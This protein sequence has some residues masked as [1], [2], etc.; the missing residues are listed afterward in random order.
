MAERPIITV[1]YPDNPSQADHFEGP[2]DFIVPADWT[3]IG[4]ALL[5]DD[6]DPI[7]LITRNGGLIE[8]DGELQ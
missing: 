1:V 4:S 8:I 6:F 7:G 5:P 2:L 3:R